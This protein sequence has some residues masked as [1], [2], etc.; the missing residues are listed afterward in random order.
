MSSRGTSPKNERSIQ[1]ASGRFMAVYRMIRTWLV[2]SRSRSRAMIQSGRMA[3]TMG[4]NFVEMKKKSTS[5][6]PLTG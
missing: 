3:A 1:I 4:R 2:L 5:R 6:Q